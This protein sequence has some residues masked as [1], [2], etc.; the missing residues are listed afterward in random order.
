[1]TDSRGY[2]DSMD[3]SAHS[4]DWLQTTN[5]GGRRSRGRGCRCDC[6]CNCGCGDRGCV[7]CCCK[8]GPTGATGA[9]GATGPF[10]YTQHLLMNF[11]RGFAA[12]R[13][14]LSLSRLGCCGY[15]QCNL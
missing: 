15:S 5:C 2:S 9:T 11:D 10:I 4:D 6:D 13:R 3:N 8:R 7:C 12:I 1:M 14:R